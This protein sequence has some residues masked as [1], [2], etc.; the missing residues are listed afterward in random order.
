[1]EAS[2]ET[3]RDLSERVRLLEH[4][5]VPIRRPA[6]EPAQPVQIEA[7]HRIETPASPIPKSPPDPQTPRQPRFKPVLDSPDDGE[8][9][10]TRIG[11]RWLLYIGIF[12]IIVGASYFEKLAIDNHWISETARVIQGAIAGGLFI[13]GGLAFVR[14]GYRN[15]GQILS[16]CGI[17]IL[18]ISTYAAFNFYHLIA[19]GTAFGVMAAVTLLAAS[20][21]DRH[22]S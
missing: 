7:P 21:A 17:A 15:Y 5:D 14:K 1:L 6:Q 22:V 4:R 20:V 18:Y 16:G 2:Q 11:A 13:A 10:E 3:V 8:A 19:H 9:L 12:A